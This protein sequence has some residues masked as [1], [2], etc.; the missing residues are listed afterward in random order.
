M[1]REIEMAS[2]SPLQMES[3]LEHYIPSLS[4]SLTLWNTHGVDSQGR[5]INET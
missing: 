3:V 2:G 1:S 4:F 5:A